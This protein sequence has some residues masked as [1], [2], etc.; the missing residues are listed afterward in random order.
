MGKTW[1][2]LQLALILAKFLGQSSEP[3]G[4]VPLLVPVQR[5]ALL[6]R[7]YPAALQQ[8]GAD[9]VRFYIEGNFAGEERQMLLQVRAVMAL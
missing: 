7:C 6:M 3:V 5:L 8:S 1:S 4:L 2:L 9:L